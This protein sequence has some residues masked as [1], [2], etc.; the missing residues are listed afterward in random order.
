MDVVAFGIERNRVA[1]AQLPRAGRRPSHVARH[2]HS[3]SLS[4][5][6]SLFPAQSSVDCARFFERGRARRFARIST[7]RGR[8][9]ARR[10][11]LERAQRRGS[12]ETNRERGSGREGGGTKAAR[13]PRGRLPRNRA[14]LPR[15]FFLKND[16]GPAANP[17]GPEAQPRGPEAHPRGPRSA[18]QSAG[19]GAA[20]R[21][22]AGLYDIASFHGRSARTFRRL[23]TVVTRSSWTERAFGP[24]G[25][26]RSP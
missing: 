24:K 11:P 2:R 12:N 4:L 6:F 14:D 5:S 25:A 20:S 13:A 23:G 16:N 21:P 22:M 26:T 15:D 1:K 19:S 18:A 9:R 3:L 17:R 8:T 7:T 10:A